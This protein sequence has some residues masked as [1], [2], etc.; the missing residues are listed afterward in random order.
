VE[1]S[2]LLAGDYQILRYRR[3]VENEPTLQL[4]EEGREEYPVLKEA[5]HNPFSL[6]QV[7]A[8]E[9]T[10]LGDLLTHEA[11]SAEVILRDNRFVVFLLKGQE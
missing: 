1:G 2:F 3:P 6:V 4:E 5:L 11:K 7:E 9:G 10:K 8:L